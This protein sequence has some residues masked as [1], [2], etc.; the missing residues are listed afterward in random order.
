MESG[1]RKRDLSIGRSAAAPAPFDRGP[2]RHILHHSQL[3]GSEV[4]NNIL[5]VL[6]DFFLSLP[7]RKGNGA[8][9]ALSRAS[10]SWST[11]AAATF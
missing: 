1:D 2:A 11:T 5:Y 4:R 3:Y 10:E 8:M 6:T 9:S 7:T